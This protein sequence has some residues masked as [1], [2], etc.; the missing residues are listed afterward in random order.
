MKRAQVIAFSLVAVQTLTTAGCSH[1]QSQAPVRGPV[2]VHVAPVLIERASLP[3]TATGTLALKDEVPL[4]F[5]VGGVVAR[6]SIKC[7]LRFCLKLKSYVISFLGTNN[8]QIEKLRAGRN[9]CVTTFGQ[10]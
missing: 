5:K 7:E 4:S 6:T 8:V 10:S 9:S 3:I 2:T 1:R